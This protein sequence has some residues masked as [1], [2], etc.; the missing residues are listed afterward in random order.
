MRGDP[1][2]QYNIYPAM[3]RHSLNS[4][5]IK[6]FRTAEGIAKLL[7]A[8][9]FTQVQSTVESIPVHTSPTH[10]SEGVLG[11]HFR[12][13]LLLALRL[14]EEVADALSEPR[15]S[16]RLSVIRK[17]RTALSKKGDHRNETM[18]MYLVRITAQK[19]GTQPG[20]Q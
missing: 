19:L 16:K 3:I 9:S 7:E 5:G 18:H 12:R 4:I 11:H 10:S 2:F 8:A 1:L 13:L 14:V 15:R 17:I 6:G 20:E